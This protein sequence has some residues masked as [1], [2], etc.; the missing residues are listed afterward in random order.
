MKGCQVREIIGVESEL[1]M[2]AI[3]DH[4]SLSKILDILV[5]ELL[6]LLSRV[7]ELGDGE[8]PLF[9]WYKS[10]SEEG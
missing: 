8:T 6:E 5:S 2:E 10:L 9:L 3:V 1:S 7:V 4:K